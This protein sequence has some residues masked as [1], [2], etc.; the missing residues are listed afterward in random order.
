MLQEIR[1]VFLGFFFES[2]TNAVVQTVKNGLWMTFKMDETRCEITWMSLIR[3][4]I[5]HCPESTSSFVE[6]VHRCRDQLENSEFFKTHDNK[7]G[8]L[9]FHTSRI[10]CEQL[11]ELNAHIPTQHK[12]T[13][14]PFDS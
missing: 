3:Q 1:L 11:V 10:D 2:Q 4:K 8:L 9:Q 12:L 6:L 5:Y 13:N 14:G 7:L